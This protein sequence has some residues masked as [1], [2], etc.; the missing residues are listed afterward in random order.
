MSTHNVR[1][2]SVENI[3]SIHVDT[4]EQEGGLQGIRDVGLL[5]SAAAMPRSTFGGAYLHT[6]LA[7]MAAAYLYHICQNHAFVDGNK[8]T[9]A[10]SCV[11]FLYLNGI[12]QENLPQESDLEEVTLKIASG[13]MTK[14]EVIEW[15]QNLPLA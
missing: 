7:A 4:L 15:L 9:A 5:E 12:A 11:L 8:R 14:G 10:F 2:L 1:F 6:D 13:S 3:L